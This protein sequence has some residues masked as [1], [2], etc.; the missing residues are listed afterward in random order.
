MWRVRPDD[1][2]WSLERAHS[3]LNDEERARAAR[4][5]FE[6]HRRR[7]I[8]RRAARRAILASYT[9][10]DPRVLV[11]TENDFGKPSLAG[12]PGAGG[13]RF[14]ASA[15]A[16]LAVIAIGTEREIGID[17]EMVRDVPDAEDLVR[18]FFSA[19]ERS[20]LA[21]LTQTE[22]RSAFLACWTRKE[23]Y[24]KAVGRGISMPLDAFDVSVLPD[25]PA[26]LL[27]TRPDPGEVDRWSM[28]G[29]DAGPDHIGALVVAGA[30]AAIRVVDGPPD[31]LAW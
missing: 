8:V 30:P 18:R 22:R 21:R 27:A 5:R 19:T 14:N 17:V 4:F 13:L 31:K 7:F 12:E 9:G 15:S 20:A 28:H 11:F 29:F 24:V 1:P 26:V 3:L 23:A 10:S 6:D 2:A 16:E 25:A